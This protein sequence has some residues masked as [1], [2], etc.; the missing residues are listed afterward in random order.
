MANTVSIEDLADAIVV[1]LEEY[2]QDTTEQLKSEIRK[3]AKETVAEISANSPRKTGVYAKGWKAVKLY[4]SNDDIRFRIQNKNK[5]QL[6]PL[7][8]NGY[9]RR[10][11]TRVAGRPHISPAEKHA[12]EKLCKKVKVIYGG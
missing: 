2:K 6:T 11:G 8:E 5:H 4:E 9:V 12:E 3:V 1:E 7:L 10:N